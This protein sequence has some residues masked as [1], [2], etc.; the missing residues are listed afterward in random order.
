VSVYTEGTDSWADI[1]VGNPAN[2]KYPGAFSIN[3]KIYF[4][5]GINATLTNGTNREVWEFDPSTGTMTRKADI[6]GSSR[7][8]GFSFAVG[9]YGYVGCGYSVTMV[10]TTSVLLTDVYRYDPSSDTWQN[11]GTFPGGPKTTP[12]SFVIGKKAYVLTGYNSTNLTA[13]VWEFYDP[14]NQ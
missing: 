3:N 10:P 14:V 12:V 2:Y 9:N 8:A 13:D 7:H 1:Y 5:G 11:L 4:I 6:P